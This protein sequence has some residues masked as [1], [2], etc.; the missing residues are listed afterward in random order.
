MT[1]RSNIRRARPNRRGV[2]LI[3]LAVVLS[4]ASAGCSSAGNGAA[5]SLLRTAASPPTTARRSPAPPS[6]VSAPTSA[7]VT[8]PAQPTSGPGGSN[9]PFRGWRVTAGGSGVNAWYVFEPTLPTP[10]SA[11]VAII[12]HGYYQFAGY[13]PMYELIRH[14]VL[15]G[16][17]VIYPRWQTDVSTPC[18][19][20][21]DIE[22]CMTSAVNGIRGALAYLR[23]SPSRVQ[24]QLA[25]TSYFGFSFG[26]IITV[27][28]ANRYRS[29]GLPTPR[30]VFLD[31]PHDGGLNGFNEPA[32]DAT[33]T[34]IPSSVLLVCH[35]GA[36][37]VI[38]EPNKADSSC[39]S[40]YPKLGSIP[41]VNKSL[42]LTEPDAHG[43]PALSSKHGVCQA[44][45]G[46]ADAYDWNFCW[47]VW[48]A[49]QSTAYYHGPNR[50][51]A[52]GNTPEQR[53]NGVWSDSIPI[54][55]LKVQDAAP[56]R[57]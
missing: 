51:Y 36:E 50:R 3:M 22:P 49:L 48:D 10:R 28:L 4:L 23:A 39:N 2:R 38:S 42:V 14:T 31:D 37:G 21:F 8:Q 15:K 20:P 27:N 7:L 16:S 34:G 46:H 6:T 47:K 17:I 57:P 13:A 54:A 41:K 40:I 56:I 18:P 32:V 33:L 55:P 35:V 53:S 25:M 5:A 26:G 43:A 12:M 44:L 1:A 52:L 11:P 30:V 19:G 45:R 24:P 9:L 29:L